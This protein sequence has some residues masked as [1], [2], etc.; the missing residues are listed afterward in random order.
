MAIL[1]QA[2]ASEVATWLDG[3][4][5]GADQFIHTLVPLSANQKG[6]LSFLMQQ[7]ITQE[8]LGVVLVREPIEGLSCIVV[9]NPK[10]AMGAL[11]QRL[12]ETGHRGISPLADIHPAATIH[13]TAVVDS[14]VII[15][16]GCSVGAESHIGPNV[17]LYSGSHIGDNCIVQA[18]AIIG[19]AGF[20]YEQVDGQLRHVTHGGGVIIEDDVHIGA[21]VCIDQGM[22]E[23]TRIARGVKIDNL[24]HIGH[25]SHI[26]IGTIIAAQSG[27]SG[28][29]QIGKGVMIGGQV[30]ISDH[31]ILED[32]VQV[33]AK[34]GVH[35]RLK[36][37]LAYFGIPAIP[38]AQAFELIRA[39]RR[40]PRWMQNR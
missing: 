24:V 29:A 9:K 1:C 33:A 22:L 7:T 27:V 37:G 25:N 20:A 15:E 36:S 3:Q 40:L 18:G 30:G 2:Q 23:P 14:G 13:P 26:G 11:I 19:A 35:G 4:L 12:S 17:V 34:S 32:G 38:K 16:A 6:R 21:N 8:V 39:V 10:W 5:H 31:A 28:S